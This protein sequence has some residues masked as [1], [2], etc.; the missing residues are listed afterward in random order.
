MFHIALWV[1]RVAVLG[2]H[3]LSC[4]TKENLRKTDSSRRR[5]RTQIMPIIKNRMNV[6]LS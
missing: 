2:P 3:M 1:F 6:L 5:R 4:L